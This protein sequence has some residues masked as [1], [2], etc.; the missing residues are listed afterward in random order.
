MKTKTL[1]VVETT[2]T[3]EFNGPWKA[4]FGRVNRKKARHY[5]KHHRKQKWYRIVEV[6]I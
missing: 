4:E 1:H 3:P 6:E 2:A 5:G